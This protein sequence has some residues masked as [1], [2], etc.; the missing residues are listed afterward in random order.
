MGLESNDVVGPLPVDAFQQ[1]GQMLP[2]HIH[3][4]AHHLQRRALG[5]LGARGIEVVVHLGLTYPSRFTL[6]QHTQAALPH[7][8]HR[9]L[10]DDVLPRPSCW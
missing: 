1:L 7:P 2:A 4:V 10:I 5:E 3:L 8:K 9:A 6:V